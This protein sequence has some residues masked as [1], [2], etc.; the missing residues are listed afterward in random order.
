MN[1]GRC[2]TFVTTS[3]L[4]VGDSSSRALEKWLFSHFSSVEIS[5]RWVGTLYLALASFSVA[6]EALFTSIEKSSANSPLG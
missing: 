2:R 5:Y 1:K 4:V 6:L 3:G